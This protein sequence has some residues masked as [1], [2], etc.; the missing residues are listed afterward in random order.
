VSASA[1][2]LIRLPNWLGDVL[3]ARPL[4][5]AVRATWPD[6][7]VMG[8]APAP[9]LDLLAEERCLDAREPWAREGGARGTL[10]ERVRAWRPTA[11]LVLPGSFSSAW[12]AFRAAIPV[13]VGFRGDGRSWLLTRAL[14]RRARG[15]LHLSLEFL[16]LGREIGARSAA[17]PVLEVGTRARTAARALLDRLG[18]EASAPYA[19]LGP[20]SAWGPAREWPAER[21]AAVGRALADR[22]RAVLVCGTAAERESCERV[23]AAV[24]ARARAIAGDTD[25]PVLAALAARSSVTVCND[26]GLAHLAA[27]VGAPTIQI[28]GSAS[29]AWTHALGAR[30]RILH[31]AP[32]CSP[33]YQR[34]CR[35]GYA[36]LTAIEAA[37]VVRACEEIAA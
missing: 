12:F 28:Y 26:S 37:E 19:L 4:L 17:T 30:V 7:A 33:C 16:E 2:I 6:A 20:R 23:A 13:R 15:A 34:T 22:G 27:A 24:G 29:S 21:F 14:P 35:I 9:F 18:I 1:R 31:R 25:L 11:A 8:V 5:H 36:C 32:V 10:L 3:L